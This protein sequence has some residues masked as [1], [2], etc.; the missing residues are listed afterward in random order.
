MDYKVGERVVSMSESCCGGFD[1][2]TKGV[3]TR[4]HDDG[5]ISVQAEYKGYEITLRHCPICLQKVRGPK[6]KNE[7]TVAEA[8]MTDLKRGDREWS[9]EITNASQIDPHEIFSEL[10]RKNP[11]AIVDDPKEDFLIIAIYSTLQFRMAD[12]GVPFPTEI[13]SEDFEKYTIFFV[14]REQKGLFLQGCREAA[15]YQLPNEGRR[16]VTVTLPKLK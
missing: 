12:I 15:Q 9:F 4:L 6:P 13:L 11:V 5:D 8:Q 7:A 1:K 3:V 10:S 2:G 14:P 16:R